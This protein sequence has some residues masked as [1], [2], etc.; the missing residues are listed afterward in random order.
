MRFVYGRSNSPSSNFLVRMRRLAS[1]IRAIGT[2]PALT[3]AGSELDELLRSSV[4]TMTMS[5]PA[6]TAVRTSARGRAGAP[7]DLVDAVP[8]GDHEAGEAQLDP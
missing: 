2:R 3:S 4:G 6:L 8:V 5:M 7:V 1:S